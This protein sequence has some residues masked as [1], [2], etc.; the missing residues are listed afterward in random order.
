MTTLV[1]GW[2]SDVDE[3]G[4]GI[5]VAEGNDGDVDI[6]SLL[7]SLGVGAGI[8]DND[9]AGFLEGAGDVVS[10]V[11]GS[12]TTCDGDGSGVGGELQDCA[13]AVGTGGNNTDVGGVIDGC[14]NAGCEDNF[15][16]E[17][18]IYVRI[19]LF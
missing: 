11:T 14:Y 18:R 13:L 19:A 4:R 5:G 16:P 10:E 9:E 7:D 15:L 3:L 8:R 17:V 6:G 12:E 1:V 2:D